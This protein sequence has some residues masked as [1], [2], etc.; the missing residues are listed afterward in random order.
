M[1][2]RILIR[3]G[4]VTTAVDRWTGDILIE[5]GRIV[6][7][8]A[9]LSADADIHDAAGLLVLPGGVDVHTHIDYDTGS[10]RTADTFETATRAA[11][12]GGTTTVVD[13]AFQPRQ[14][15]SVAAALDDWIKRAGSACVD[16]GAHMM[17]TTV[18][19]ATLAETRDLVRN[20]GV[21]SVKLFMAYPDT[22]MVDD[23]ALWRVMRQV[24]EDGGLVCLHA[25]NGALIQAL[26]EEALAAGRTA[27]RYHASTRPSLTE[28]EAVHRAVVISELSGAPIY[29]VH[30]ST[31]EGVEEVTHARDRGLPVY[32][33]T[34]P[35]YLFLD[36]SAYDTDDFQAGAKVVFTPPLRGLDH[37]RALWRGL[38]TGDLQVVSTDHCPFCVSETSVSPYHAK[39]AGVSDFTRIPNGAPGIETR[40][41][42]LFDAAVAKRRMDLNRFVALTATNP[43]KLFGLFPRKGTIA[44]GSD[45]DLVLFDPN[46]TTTVRASDHHSRVDYS[47]F[48]GWTLRGAVRKVF[49]R[50]E[51]IVDG[52]L[53]RGRPG[54]GR[55]L[56][57]EAS[58]RL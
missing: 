19:P 8:G 14:A 33:E 30:L 11:A 45:A 1:T 22:L 40:M 37:Q 36:E 48:E 42:L 34:C 15:P 7:L 47:L 44:V 55:F 9:A 4:Q 39:R 38:A 26:I 57:R 31:R 16:V 58:G 28:G 6:A 46:A 54:A 2:K 27:P 5:D 49:S 56:K 43:A 51:L 32:A 3:G 18:T 35:H 52:P 13:F 50:G 10:A 29:L 41:P 17:L 25:E 21:T 53:W 23:G 12:F 24:G 20:G